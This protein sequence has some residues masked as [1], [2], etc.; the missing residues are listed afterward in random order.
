MKCVRIISIKY[1]LLWEIL[2]K[3]KV[4]RFSSRTYGYNLYFHLQRIILKKYIEK[5]PKIIGN[6]SGN[7]KEREQDQ[8][9]DWCGNF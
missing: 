5:D 9:R 8:R 2:I 1:F 4:L 3:G 6:K 7:V